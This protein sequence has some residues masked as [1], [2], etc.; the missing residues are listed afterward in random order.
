MENASQQQWFWLDFVYYWKRNY[1]ISIT[2]CLQAGWLKRIHLQHKFKW[3][4]SIVYSM[5][6]IYILNNFWLIEWVWWI[7]VHLSAMIW[8]Y[9]CVFYNTF[10]VLYNS[11]F[12]ND[13]NIEYL[14]QL[15]HLTPS[16]SGLPTYFLLCCIISIA[17]TTT[18]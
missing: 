16:L 17:S 11:C 1:S 2:L 4:L 15:T 10:R 13:S 14:I 7:H 12:L 5:G 8:L 6:Y 3:S 9:C 18:I